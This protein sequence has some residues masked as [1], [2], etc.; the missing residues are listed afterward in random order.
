MKKLTNTYLLVAV[1]ALLMIS[2]GKDPLPGGIQGPGSPPT[3]P[4]DPVIASVSISGSTADLRLYIHSSHPLSNPQSISI[5]GILQE[6]FNIQPGQNKIW[7]L[8]NLNPGIYRATLH[9]AQTIPYD[10]QSFHYFSLSMEI[11]DANGTHR[12]NPT[13]FGA[14]TIVFDIKVIN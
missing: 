9:L 11:T 8:N 10:S 3:Q 4:P 1:F 14:S 6:E 13:Q 5:P 12:V 2:C 7:K